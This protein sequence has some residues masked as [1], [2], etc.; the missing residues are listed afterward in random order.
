VEEVLVGRVGASP[1]S[2]A[3]LRDAGATPEE[4]VLGAVL[5]RHTGAPSGPLVREVHAGR[6]SWGRVLH[7]AGLEPKGLDAVVRALVRGLGP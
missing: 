1:A 3:A 6:S 4:L 2:L 7:D 5:A